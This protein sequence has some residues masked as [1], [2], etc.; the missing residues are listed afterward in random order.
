MEMSP[1]FIII[2]LLDAVILLLI[3]ILFFR[4]SGKERI[5]P[6]K[7]QLQLKNLKSSLDRAMTDSEKA[8]HELLS[9]FEERL[10]ELTELLG[11]IE[12]KEKQIKEGLK[13]GQQG[14]THNSDLNTYSPYKTAASLIKQ[15][16]S[17]EEI[18]KKCG[19]SLSE[20]NLIKQLSKKE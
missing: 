7:E 3:V 6:I 10:K 1:Q 14:K 15:G 8:S 4:T 9:L 5:L 12:E 11:K 18:N 13:T 20:I 19:I 17:N 2:L 16:L